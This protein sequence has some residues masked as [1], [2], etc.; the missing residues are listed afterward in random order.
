MCL[1]TKNNPEKMLGTKTF[2]E[3][4]KQVGKLFSNHK[5]AI[6]GYSS[7]PVCRREAK[8]ISTAIPGGPGGGGA[9]CS[10]QYSKR[11]IRFVLIL[12][13]RAII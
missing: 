5:R 7:F 6:V 10:C 4:T 1:L 11:V 13:G 8:A 9:M 2:I 3:G 12:T